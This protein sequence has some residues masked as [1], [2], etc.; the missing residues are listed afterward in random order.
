MST[1]NSEF[2]FSSLIVMLLLL[3]VGFFIIK[4]IFALTIAFV[5]WIIFGV[6]ALAICSFILKAFF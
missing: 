2:S 3:F 5:T 6:V 4:I 1:T